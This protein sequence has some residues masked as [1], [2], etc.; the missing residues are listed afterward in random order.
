MNFLVNKLET[1]KLWLEENDGELKDR[2]RIFASQSSEG[3]EVNNRKE[4]EIDQS[5]GSN[6]SDEHQNQLL[7]KIRNKASDNL[8]QH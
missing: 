3:N 8:L 2:K 5:T 7:K 1:L 6:S 4:S